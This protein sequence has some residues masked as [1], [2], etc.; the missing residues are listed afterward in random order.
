MSFSIKSNKINNIIIRVRY[1][2]TKVNNEE[3]NL[4]LELME[5]FL[6]NI[7]FSLIF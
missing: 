6:K 3:D 2:E 7:D 5:Y 1:S 4:I